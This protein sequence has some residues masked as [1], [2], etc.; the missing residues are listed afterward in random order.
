MPLLW[1][2]IAG[3]G[4]H[5]MERM[6]LVRWRSPRA[7]T[8]ASARLRLRAHC[9]LFHLY[10]AIIAGAVTP[11]LSAP[12]PYFHTGGTFHLAISRLT[13]LSHPHLR[14]YAMG[15]RLTYGCLA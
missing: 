9:G 3:L 15:D 5:R 10:T 14:A 7:A 13:C 6:G 12:P 2:R 11:P 1:T 8:S 4:L